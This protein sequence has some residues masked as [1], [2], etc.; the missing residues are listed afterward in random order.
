MFRRLGASL[1]AGKTEI[2]LLSLLGVGLC[3]CAGNQA[4]ASDD[5]PEPTALD[6]HLLSLV[7]D[8]QTLSFAIRF[9]DP[10]SE[11]NESLKEIIV[12]MLSSKLNDLT[13][14]LPTTENDRVI[15][16]A[17]RVHEK[18]T[19]DIFIAT[20]SCAEAELCEKAHGLAQV[21]VTEGFA[22]EEDIAIPQDE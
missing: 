12:D 14:F 17:C 21:C 20:D 8:V 10:A 13:L 18:A 7:E 22:T 16:L 2:A 11:N 15:G 3:G 19:N 9:I 5:E 1:R 6:A 4:I